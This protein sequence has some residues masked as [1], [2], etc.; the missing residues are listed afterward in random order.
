[1]LLL[2]LC[3]LQWSETACCR[4]AWTSVAVAVALFVPTLVACY[5]RL[6]LPTLH[7]LIVDRSL[8][9]LSFNQK[10]DEPKKPKPEKQPQQQQQQQQ[11]QKQVRQTSM[12]SFASISHCWLAGTEGKGC[13]AGTT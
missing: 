13:G 10:S 2:L 1:L 4:L 12:H 9:S 7:L 8:F 5:L 3:L 11:Q 6:T